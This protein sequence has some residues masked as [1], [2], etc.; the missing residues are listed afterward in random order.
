MLVVEIANLGDPSGTALFADMS[1]TPGQPPL[2]ARVEADE[3]GAVQS[4]LDRAHA[5]DDDFARIESWAAALTLA[6]SARMGDPANGVDRN[7]IAEA[8]TV[9]GLE[10]YATQ[11]AIFDGLSEEAQ[12]DLLASVAQ[13]AQDDSSTE[14][15]L[16]WLR[17]D[18]E[19]MARLS[20]SSMLANAEIKRALLTD[21]NL[22]W[23][24]EIIAMLGDGEQPF[25]AVGAA[26]LFGEE[27]LPALL[28]AGG[29]SVRRIQ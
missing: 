19:A 4:L 29:Y 11:L 28:V 14:M 24:A 7:L 20:A 18:D 10:S 2:T 9:A 25:V 17:G 16:A 23:S 26:H 27:G 22:Q 3:R 12:S 5:S 15:L 8:N 13:S 6:A 21:R 1:E